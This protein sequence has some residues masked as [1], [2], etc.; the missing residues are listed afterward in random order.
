MTSKQS[1]SLLAIAIVAFIMISATSIA[2]PGDA[3]AKETCA[4]KK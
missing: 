2:G 1:L 3:S 4:A